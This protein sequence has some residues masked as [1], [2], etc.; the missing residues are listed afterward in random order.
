M[1]DKRPPVLIL[2]GR[3]GD[4]IQV[5]SC[6]KA[7]YDRTGMRPIIIVCEEYKAVLEGMSYITPH[8]IPGHWYGAIPTAQQ[9][10]R[11]KYG[12]GTLVQFWQVPP[13]HEDT[14]G[15]QGRRWATIQS[16]GHNWGV[17]LDL[18][19]DYGTSMA[20]R[21]GFSSEEWMKL[22]VVFDKRNPERE[23]ALCQSLLSRK[24][25]SLLYNFAGISSPFAH[26][27]EVLAVLRSFSNAFHLVNLGGIKAGKIFDLLGLMDRAA[28]MITTDTATLHLAAAS[29][30]P[31]IALTVDGWTS[32]RPKG[33]VQLEIKYS[34]AMNQIPKLRHVIAQF[35][36][37]QL[38][39]A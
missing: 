22:P 2:L 33:N 1:I 8:P 37:Q 3:N 15:W 6:W 5:S 16:H 12:G 26:T 24:K 31:Y 9:L 4:L 29:K 11:D 7:I 10:A 20:R 13:K 28:L 14:I 35:A 27:A 18:D 23:A 19:P 21:C 36:A 39:A 25:P 17:N 30:I 34:Q 38:K 32:S